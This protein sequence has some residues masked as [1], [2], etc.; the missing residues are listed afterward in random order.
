MYTKDLD[1][2]LDR[3]K[4]KPNDC[5]WNELFGSMA[6]DLMQNYCIEKK[7]SNALQTEEK[8][9]TYFFEE[10]EFYFY[11]N[12]K[13]ADKDKHTDN[14]NAYPRLCKKGQW[15]VHYS[16]VDIAFETVPNKSRD[17]IV[18]CGGI[19]IRG[20]RKS[21]DE[22]IA[23]PLRCLTELFNYCK[24]FPEIKKLETSREI[25]ILINDTRIGI[26]D[27]DGNKDDNRYRYYVNNS[28]TSHKITDVPQYHKDSIVIK[29][30]NYRYDFNQHHKQD[31]GDSQASKSGLNS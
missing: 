17:E 16:G 14:C 29:P 26:H 21:N 12:D 7:Y 18:Q 22:M 5:D 9:E 6:E 15:F 10:I 23:G 28:S 25:G 1:K 27:S 13:H 8:T 11:Y 31:S 30:K 3:I 24:S 4:E 19:L 20:L 2:L